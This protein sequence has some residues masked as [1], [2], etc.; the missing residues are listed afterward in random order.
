[1]ESKSELNPPCKFLENSSY[2]GKKKARSGEGSPS[3]KID[4]ILLKKYGF[5]ECSIFKYL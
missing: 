2:I 5:I 4:K 1:M 3:P